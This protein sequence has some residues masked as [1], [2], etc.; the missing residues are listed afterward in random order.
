LSFLAPLPSPLFPVSS[1]RGGV[2]GA[3]L[4]ALGDLGES[5]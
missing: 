4:R 5:R 3:G 1:H 2:G